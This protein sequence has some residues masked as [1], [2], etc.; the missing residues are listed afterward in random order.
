LFLAATDPDVEIQRMAVL[1]L[2]A[3]N[4]TGAV[5][6]LIELLSQSELLAQTIRA[7][8]QMDDPR[9]VDPLL[10]VL[11]AEDLPVDLRRPIPI[12]LGRRQVTRALPELLGMLRDP[13]TPFRIEIIDALGH[14]KDERALTRLIEL[15][16]SDDP[17]VIG[18][19]NTAL[20]RITGELFD[21]D[22]EA[23]SS[24]LAGRKSPPQAQ[25]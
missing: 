16:E 18:A 6:L 8:G 19:V 2:G 9:V 13:E 23:W 1:G 14:M 15:L 3:L 25:D 17:Y 24:W 20:S 11:R 22:P 12:I 10:T 21:P 5:P 4:A 7:L